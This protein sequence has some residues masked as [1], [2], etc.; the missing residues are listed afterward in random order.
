MRNLRILINF[1]VDIYTILLD[2]ITMIDKI[3]KSGDRF[4]AFI[5]T[6]EEHLFSIKSTW[7][8]RMSLIGSG[9]VLLL[10]GFIAFAVVMISI[11][12]VVGKETYK[13]YKQT[14]IRI[15]ERK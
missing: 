15:W 9:L 3:L 14:I 2:N 8:R 10:I 6:M 12:C 7:K 4:F 13:D 1:L 5:D 11:G